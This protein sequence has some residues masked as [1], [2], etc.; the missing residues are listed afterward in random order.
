[1]KKKLLVFLRAYND[2][3]HI[4][5][6]IYKWLSTENVPTD[7]VITSSPDYLNDYRIQFLKQF[8]NLQVHFIDDFLPEEKRRPLNL[9]SPTNYM[10]RYHPIGIAYKI[11]SRSFGSS[12]Q[13]LP[14]N[15]SHDTQFVE[16]ML[17]ILFEGTDKGIIVF[18]WTFTDFVKAVNEVAKRRGFTT[19]SLPHGDRPFCNLMETLNDLDYS[20]LES[21]TDKLDIFDYRVYPNKLCADRWELNT[22]AENVRILGSPR[23]NDEWLDIISPLLPVYHP[24]KGHYGLKIAFFLR[25]FNYPIFWEEV[26]R[27]VRLILQFPDVNL[28]LKHHTRSATVPQLIQAYPELNADN[29]P[30]LESVYDDVHSGSLL[31]WADVVLDLGT[32]VVFEAV[33]RGKPVLAMEYLHANCSTVAHYMRSCDVQCRDDLYDC[34]QKF[35]Q[36]GTSSF[37]EETERQRFIDEM[38]DVPD[39]YVLERY[40]QFLKSCF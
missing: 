5:P 10:R 40:V 37:Y 28:T 32:S 35:L 21:D 11:W 4:V 30:N 38:I 3:D 27:T 18:D 34:I 23:Y 2:I 16:R 24:A 8:N 29:I 15:A 7:I 9:K 12:P 36:N 33:K 26:I 19:I 20:R 22:N 31:E 17:D 14:E 6:V 39:P 1:M 25:N 13:T